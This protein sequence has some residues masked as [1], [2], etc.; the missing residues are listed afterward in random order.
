[1][2]E[3]RG[4]GADASGKGEMELTASAKSSGDRV[5]LW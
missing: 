1:M 4:K 5:R 2:G 3:L